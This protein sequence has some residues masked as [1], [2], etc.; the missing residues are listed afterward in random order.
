MP[1]LEQDEA[2]NA[3]HFTARSSPK[4]NAVLLFTR[5]GRAVQVY[6]VSRIE[7]ADQMIGWSGIS[8][9]RKSEQGKHKISSII[10]RSL[11]R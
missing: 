8:A 5:I 9:C 3:S 6:G 11:P 7:K 2:N 1:I 10:S 4:V